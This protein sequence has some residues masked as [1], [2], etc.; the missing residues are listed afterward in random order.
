MPEN[1][2][3][4]HGEKVLVGVVREQVVHAENILVSGWFSVRLATGENLLLHGR[5]KVWLLAGDTCVVASSGGPIVINNMYCGTAILIGGRH[6][7][8]VG[9]LKARKAYTRRV[10]V[11]ELRTHEW[12]SSAMSG[13]RKVS[14]SHILFM[15]PHSYMVEVE[16]L[17]SVTYGY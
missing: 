11:N 3:G 14:A 13:V 4:I 17:G 15:D 9:Y 16:Y 2:G 5:G 8:I 12:V 1:G 7:V 6:P 10:M